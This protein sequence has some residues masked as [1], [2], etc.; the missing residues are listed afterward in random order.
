MCTSYVVAN[1]SSQVRWRARRDI[2]DRMAGTTVTPPKERETIGGGS[3]LGDV[4]RI[5]V[6]NDNHNSFE[7]VASAL[8]RVLPGVNYDK[9][10][11]LASSIH[12]S[13]QAIVWS[14]QREQAE[15]YWEQLNEAGLTMAPLEG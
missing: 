15:L 12:S 9:G 8:S 3:T 10:M 14:G 1:Y 4:S 7:G 11:T 6:L 13:G 2:L 5:V